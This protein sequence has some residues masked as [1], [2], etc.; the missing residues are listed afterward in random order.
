[1]REFSDIW[2]VCY[3]GGGTSNLQ[4]GAI[5]A[6]DGVN[7]EISACTFQQNEAT[8][9]S[10]ECEVVLKLFPQKTFRELSSNWRGLNGPNFNQPPLT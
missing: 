7:M 2:Y 4:G 6:D 1:M 5:Y 10:A 8:Y 9:V 3:V